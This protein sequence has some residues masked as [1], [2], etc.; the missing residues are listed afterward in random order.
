[1]AQKLPKLYSVYH[2]PGWEGHMCSEAE[3]FFTLF[4]RIRKESV[5]ACISMGGGKKKNSVEGAR[6]TQ[7]CQA[8]KI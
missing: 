4:Q 1:M 8:Y 2:K 3:W 5:P 6:V 7:T